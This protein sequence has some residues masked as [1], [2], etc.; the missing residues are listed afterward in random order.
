MRTAGVTLVALAFAAPMLGAQ[1]RVVVK[2]RGFETAVMLDT[3][4]TQ[5][6]VGAP[7]DKVYQAA[8]IVFEAVGIPVNTKD[9]RR[10]IIAATRFAKVHSLAGNQLAQFFSC[11]SGM[12][13]PHANEWRLEI[14]V[15]ALLDPGGPGNTKLRIATVAS[16]QDVE[17]SS[18][19]PLP[20][21]STG[22]LEA[23]LMKMITVRSAEP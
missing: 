4:G 17:G 3:L 23:M 12:T 21:Y 18:K 16:G 13:G 8:L 7:V 10:G 2:L 9:P 20:C 1:Q 22:N 19:D 5:K 14:A 6:E 15:A 11:G